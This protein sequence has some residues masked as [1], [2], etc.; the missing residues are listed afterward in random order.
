MT[1]TEP[2]TATFPY[3]RSCPF[4]PPGQYQ[5]MTHDDPSLVTLRGSGLRVWTVTQYDTIRK[6]L[7]D[8]RL[9]ASRKHDNF[10]FYFIAPPEYRTETSFIGYDAPEH[11]ETRRKAAPY[12]TA[13]RVRRMR[14]RIQEIVDNHIDQMLAQGPPIDLHHAFSLPVPMTVICDILGIPQE[15]HAFFIKHGTALLGGHSTPE[16]R[17]AA[18]VEVNDYIHKLLDVKRQNPADDLLSGVLDKYGEGH[19]R[20][21]F[22]MIRLLMN[23]GHET[24][25]SQISMG[26]AFLLD[27]P[28]Q[29]ALINDDPSL[30]P[31]M[32]EEMVRIAS[33]GDNAVPR[34][35][36][37]DIQVGDKTIKKGDGIL[38]LIMA[39]NRDETAFPQGD[40]P[41]VER[42]D[43]R[44]LAF[45]HGAHHCIGAD[46][47]RLE[48]EI[49]WS[50]LFHRIPTLQLAKPIDEIPHKDGAVIYG[51]WE[52]PITW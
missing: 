37:E 52:M 36:L 23:G 2:E 34:V 4:S 11:S 38:M 27:N 26:T 35:A 28:D 46:L 13:K 7:V 10:P 44:H 47:A 21:V 33:I 30:V 19:D 29:L 16:E 24:T 31:A 32:V 15:D 22:N 45:G 43:R 41:D 39:G 50:T 5:S 18:I 40:T 8:P 25:A 3:S 17:T 49:V 51:P 20:D 1:S 14:P 42:G 48:L 9:S 12:F 6:L